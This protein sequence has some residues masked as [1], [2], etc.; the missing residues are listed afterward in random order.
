MSQREAEQPPVTL[1][2]ASASSVI[3]LGVASSFVLSDPVTDRPLANTPYYIVFHDRRI[4]RVAPDSTALGDRAATGVSDARGRTSTI[5]LDAPDSG[6]HV[7]VERIGHGEYGDLFVVKSALVTNVEEQR[8]YEI[9][10]CASQ[11]T[12]RGTLNRQGYT[13]YFASDTPCQIRVRIS[14]Q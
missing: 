5:W 14:D 4:V 9:R 7:P 1:Q 8:R 6:D 3:A 10:G 12:Y 13:V 11:D 2:T